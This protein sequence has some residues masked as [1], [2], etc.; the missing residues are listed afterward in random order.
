MDQYAR[1]RFVPDLHHL[2]RCTSSHKSI[3]QIFG[4]GI[5]GI[6]HRIGTVHATPAFRNNLFARIRPD[7][8]VMDI[9]QKPH[10]RSLYFFRISHDVV[11]VA[12]GFGIMSAAAC[13]IAVFR[14]R[15]DKR[16]QADGIESVI[17]QDCKDVAFGTIDVKEF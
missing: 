13:R 11:L 8:A 5:N 2:G 15:R 9:D 16:T 6:R 12:I 4:V 10:A 1:R 3:H 14:L 17:F 7:I